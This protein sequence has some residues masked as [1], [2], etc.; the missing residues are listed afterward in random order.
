MEKI[1]ISTKPPEQY[2]ERA[3][4][5][6]VSLSTQVEQENLLVSD[7]TAENPDNEQEDSSVTFSGPLDSYNEG[8]NSPEVE[9]PEYRNMI[10]IRAGKPPRVSLKDALAPEPH[11][12][13][14]SLSEAELSRIAKSHPDT[15]VGYVVGGQMP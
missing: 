6:K 5:V 2:L 13:R 12:K 11:V 7:E 8:I 3:Q 15:V 10:A 14:V 9:P 4:N 1:I